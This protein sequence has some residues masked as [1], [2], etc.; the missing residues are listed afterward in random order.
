MPIGGLTP[1]RVDV[2]VLAASASDPR[3]QVMAGRFRQDLLYRLAVVEFRLP[4]LRERRED[5]PYLVATFVKEAAARLGKP[6]TGL[7]PDAE[8]LLMS[9][10]WH[11]HVREL[12]SAVERACLMA[13]GPVVTARDVVSAVPAGP[14]GDPHRRP[15]MAR[16]T[17]GRCPPWSAITSC[18]RCSGRVETRRRPRA[19]WASAAARCIASWNAWTCRRPSAGA[20]DRPTVSPSGSFEQPSPAR[21]AAAEIAPGEPRLPSAASPP[22]FDAGARLCYR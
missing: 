2:V 13:E 17:G 12:Q 21:V 8:A 4:P 14:A 16:T 18:E 20:V 19:C 1:H 6:L 22:T 7:A 3:R 5:I 11:G 15:T 9:A 10:P